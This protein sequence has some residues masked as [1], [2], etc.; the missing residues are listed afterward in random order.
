MSTDNHQPVTK[1]MME[2]Y[3]KVLE[4]QVSQMSLVATTLT[5]LNTKL[6]KVEGHFTNGFKSDILEHITKTED[7][8]GSQI[9]RVTSAAATLSI[10]NER[11][12]TTL[13]ALNEK[14]AVAVMN[15]LEMS[16]AKI[17]SML[18]LSVI[19]NVIGWGSLIV[20]ILLKIFGK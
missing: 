15:K 3:V 18:K 14:N 19:S 12:A 9:E 5:E 20:T 13:A 1:E 7:K 11:N 6:E 16:M 4:K 10:V 2:I 8:I 17:E